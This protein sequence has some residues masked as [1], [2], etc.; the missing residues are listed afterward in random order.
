MNNIVRILWC[1]IWGLAGYFSV[2]AIKAHIEK[3]RV[4]EAL[5]IAAMQRACFV[6]TTTES[7]DDSTKIV[8][9]PFGWMYSTNEKE[10]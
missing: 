1:L 10:S 3:K 2:M 8:Y 5:A 6:K 7:G 9:N 4:E